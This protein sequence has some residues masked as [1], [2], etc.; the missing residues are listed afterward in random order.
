[1]VSQNGKREWRSPIL[2]SLDSFGVTMSGIQTAMAEGHCTN[3]NPPTSQF[4]SQ[5]TG[6]Y[7]PTTS[8]NLRAVEQCTVGDLTN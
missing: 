2:M 5:T 3:D 1:M 6:L 8:G 4:N 7:A